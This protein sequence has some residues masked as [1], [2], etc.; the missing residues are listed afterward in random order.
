MGELDP[1]MQPRKEPQTRRMKIT[2]CMLQKFGYT[3]GCEGCQAK[4]AGMTHQKPHG[5]DCRKRI[6]QHLTGTKL[7]ENTE[8]ENQRIA[9]SGAK[10]RGGGSNSSKLRRWPGGEDARG[11]NR[12]DE[13]QAA[14]GG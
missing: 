12:N 10:T 3:E 11:G 13:N 1:T 2:E 14:H 8:R 4:A 6:E 5:E 7:V 9:A